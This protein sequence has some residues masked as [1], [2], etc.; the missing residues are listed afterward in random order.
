MVNIVL[1]YKHSNF[2]TCHDNDLFTDPGSNPRPNITFC[3]HVS[4]VSFFWNS[5]SAFVFHDLDTL[6]PL[7]CQLSF[8]LSK[9][10]LRLRKTDI[11]QRKVLATSHKDVTRVYIN[12]C[13]MGCAP[14]SQG[15][16]H[17][18]HLAQLPSPLQALFWPMI[19]F[20]S[21]TGL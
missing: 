21:T 19:C 16:G 2:A 3:C 9:I 6:T 14:A 15:E 18:G 10:I 17:W 12:M 7:F 8:W 13:L 20:Q 11:N 4:L 5:S 1:I